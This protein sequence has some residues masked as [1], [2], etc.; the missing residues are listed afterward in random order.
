MGPLG[1]SSPLFMHDS[2]FFWESGGP[3]L[4]WLPTDRDGTPWSSGRWCLEA[5][6]H[7][8]SC[9]SLPG[10]CLLEAEPSEGKKS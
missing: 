3:S 10:R 1:G 7:T 6:A 9:P 2:D 8:V 5:A 4:P